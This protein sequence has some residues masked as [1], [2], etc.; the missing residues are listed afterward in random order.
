[1]KEESR[2]SILDAALRIARE[3]GWQAV[4]MRKIAD[5]VKHTPPVLY[6]HFLNKDAILMELARTGFAQLTAKIDTARKEHDLPEEQLESMWMA[7]WNFAFAEKEFYQLMFGIGTQGCCN[8]SSMPEVEAPGALIREVIRQILPEDQRSEERVSAVYFCMWSAIHGLVSLNMVY[9]SNTG[10]FN[11]L[12][13]LSAI[14]T[15]TA[16]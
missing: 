7:Y 3:E 11:Q 9:R 6:D 4:S 10:E 8:N 5:M 16:F 2:N 14:K 1:M 13:L 15:A 12:V